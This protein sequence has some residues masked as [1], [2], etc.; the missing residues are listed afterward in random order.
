MNYFYYLILIIIQEMDEIHVRRTPSL[1]SIPRSREKKFNQYWVA[2]FFNFDFNFS[3]LKC[4]KYFWSIF[5]F[6]FCRIN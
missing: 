1:I 4:Q 2:I 6:V 3:A 5:F